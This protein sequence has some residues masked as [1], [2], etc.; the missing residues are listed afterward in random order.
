MLNTIYM[1]IRLQLK[2][3]SMR[4]VSKIFL[5]YRPYSCYHEPPASK[6][7]P[8]SKQLAYSRDNLPNTDAQ[9]SNC[10]PNKP[11]T[12]DTLF[13]NITSN[14]N[15][16]EST[17]SFLR[18]VRP[19][20][21]LSARLGM[22]RD[23]SKAKLS[24]LV[25]AT[26]LAGYAMAP[27]QVAT[28]TTSLASEN[29]MML[30]NWLT[31]YTPNLTS[32]TSLIATLLGTALCSF[33]ANALNQWIEVPFDSQMRRTQ[34]RPLPSHALSP[35]HAFTYAMGMGVTGTAI[36]YLALPSPVP[37][38]IAVTTIVLYA[39]IYT[40][41]KRRSM[42][43]TTVGAIVGALPPLIGWAA[44]MP[45]LPPPLAIGEAYNFGNN[46]LHM[47]TMALPVQAWILP[48]ILFVWQYP[49][50]HALSY[51]LRDEY[52]RAGYCMMSV[53][54]P[55]QHTRLALLFTV[56]L[57]PICLAAVQCELATPLFLISSMIANVPLLYYAIRFHRKPSRQS[58]RSLFFASL[59][60]LPV[61]LLLLFLHKNIADL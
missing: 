5:R 16:T 18:P 11:I 61:L 56:S 40:P 53:L 57:F 58:A 28:P 30:L 43:N 12:G 14:D 4:P 2:K 17:G 7:R 44:R 35:P 13:S 1:S 8:I 47:W 50:F 39:G 31:L 34:A 55:Q 23:L 20:L 42:A 49:H 37:A 29:K 52:A 10:L 26:T 48:A 54:K 15:S 3:Q 19:R 21:S 33:S 32:I 27:S 46:M 51:N 25:V 24:G 38:C 41:M 59:Y 6:H 36:L 45:V 9:L 22:Y 60:H